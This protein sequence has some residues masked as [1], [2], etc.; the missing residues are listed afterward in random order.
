MGSSKE[1]L[2]DGELQTRVYRTLVSKS[3]EQSM[4][5]D[6]AAAG[7]GRTRKEV[8]S[9]GG[10]ITDKRSDRFNHLENHIKEIFVI[11]RYPEKRTK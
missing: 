11:F 4:Q 9:G 10:N 8:F 6:Q 5:P 1:K 7:I 3:G 2:K